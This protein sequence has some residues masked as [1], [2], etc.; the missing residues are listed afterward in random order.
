MLAAA[1]AGDGLGGGPDGFVEQLPGARAAAG[2]GA[3]PAA[4][5]GGGA[6]DGELAAAQA[7]V[8]DLQRRLAEAEAAADRWKALHGELHAFC[9]E[10]VLEGAKP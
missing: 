3:A 6:A 1:D 4:A 8:A 9:T 5:V 2:S 7:Q 10:Q